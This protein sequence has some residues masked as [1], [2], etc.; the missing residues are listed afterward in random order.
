[1][2]TANQAR[3]IDLE[4][5]TVSCAVIELAQFG[6]QRA[7]SKAYLQ[8]AM[9]LDNSGSVSTE[10]DIDKFWLEVL[11]AAHVQCDILRP[12]CW[13]GCRQEDWGETSVSKLLAHAERF[14]ALVDI[15]RNDSELVFANVCLWQCASSLM[16]HPSI[17]GDAHAF[18]LRHLINCLYSDLLLENRGSYWLSLRTGEYYSNTFDAIDIMSRSIDRSRFSLSDL[19]AVCNWVNACD[20]P[21]ALR[22]N[23]S[24]TLERVGEYQYRYLF[25]RDLLQE[26]ETGQ[27]ISQAANPIKLPTNYEWAMG[28][29]SNSS[30]ADQYRGA[31]ILHESMQILAKSPQSSSPSIQLQLD[32]VHS[33]M[34]ALVGW[35]SATRIIN[36]QFRAH[37]PVDPTKSKQPIPAP[38]AT[39]PPEELAGDFDSRKD[40]VTACKLENTLNGKQVVLNK[41]KSKGNRAV[42]QCATAIYRGSRGRFSPQKIT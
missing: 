31:A 21:S 18:A 32:S 8:E 35:A 4:G 34:S 36:G 41:D 33:H 11:I 3:L 22:A 27:P 40:G 26:Y 9:D 10:E 7:V 13:H 23:R 1:M 6:H 42:L 24:T 29:H 5:V 38:L 16:H 19:E 25:C 12:L 20:Q 37:K 15:V 14:S 2:D 30:P 28:L 39:C 17:L